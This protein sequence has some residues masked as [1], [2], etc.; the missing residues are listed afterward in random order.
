MLAKTITFLASLI[1]LTSAASIRE[2]SCNNGYWTPF[3]DRDNPSGDYDYEALSAIQNENPGKVCASPIGVDARLLNGNHYSTSGE[4]VSV[5][6]NLG[7][8]CK[9]EDQEDRKCEDYKVRFCCP[10]E[11]VEPECNN[12]Y[13][14][15]FFDRDNPSGGY[16]YESLSDIQKENPGKVCAKPTGV[17]ARLLNGDHY[18]VGGDVV[19]VGPSIGLICKNSDQSDK[20]CEDYKVRFCCP[21]EP[22]FQCPDNA[23]TAW[24]DRDNPSGTGDHEVLSVLQQE[25]PGKIC[26]SPSA[27]DAQLLNGDSYTNGGDVLSISP[28][29]G[30][31]CLNSGQSDKKCNDYKVR[32]CCFG[33]ST[34]R[35]EDWTPWFDRDNPSGYYDWEGLAS[36]QQENP[37]RV[38]SNPTAVDAQLING[39][40]YTDGGDDVVIGPTHGLTCKNDDQKDKRCN[41][42]KVRFCCSK[43]SEPPACKEEHWTQWFDRDNP[44]G[45]AD[46]EALSN[47]QVEN[48]GKICAVP[49][50]V[51]AQLLNGD[52]HTSGGDVVT[53]GAT[54]GLLCFNKLQP[55]GKCND[56]KVRFCCEPEEPVCPDNAWTDWFDRD[57]PSGGYDYEALADLQKENPGKICPS[58]SAIDAQLT[59]GTPYTDGGDILTISPTV[60]L[61]CKNSDQPDK[62]CNDYKVRFC[63]FGESTCPKE[64]WTPW[65]DRDNPGGY[66]DWEGLA[67][68]Q[69]DNPGKVCSN[70]T[71]VDAQ[72]TSGAPYTDGNDDVVIGPTHG[73]T[74]KN[75]DQDDKRCNDYKV[76]FCCSEETPSCPN[77]A[78]TQ[79]FDRDNPSGKYDY[80]ALFVLQQEN[81]GKICSSPSAVHAQLTTGAPYTDGGDNVILSAQG[82]L[83]CE[84]AA[85]DDKECEDYKVRFCCAGDNQPVCRKEDW[86]PWFDNDSPTRSNGLSDK[87]TLD[88][89]RKLYPGEICSNPSAFDAQTVAGVPYTNAGDA[90]SVGPI[91]GLVCT[92]SLQSDQACNDYK[93]RFCCDGE[94][95]SGIQDQALE[96]FDTEGVDPINTIKDDVLPSE[97]LSASRSSIIIEDH[98]L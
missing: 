59:N 89:L 4:I 68:I 77:N 88:A 60:G 84:N 82:G 64:H 44:S 36:I 19:S 14:T 79:W 22:I 73:L 15:P 21:K 41:D 24:F 94:D 48:P 55:D 85:Q 7:L 58:P 66:Y 75:D 80:E 76:R 49:S 87:E 63:C 47:L 40:P 72:L 71:A 62:K 78:W 29:N 53:V 92:G 34:C 91:F 50:A 12:G 56:Y 96:D 83:I 97:Q 65:F 43:V 9:N 8:I 16:D 5:N 27:I 31:V 17:D 2:P 38:C 39:N 28:S 93:V 74:C 57:D 32:F 10:K 26:P 33:E 13:W 52:P 95:D 51:E 45:Q 69:Q 25:N 54:I 98:L 35:K 67:A 61:I 18:S 11:I 20:K 86:T 23:W 30:L 42:Y 1:A 37:G 70:P 46:Y 3:F 6:P 90:L 81:P